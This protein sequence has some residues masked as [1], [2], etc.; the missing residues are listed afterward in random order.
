MSAWHWIYNYID[1]LEGTGIS[2][3]GVKFNI[4]GENNWELPTVIWL[5]LDLVTGT[6]DVPFTEVTES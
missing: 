1:T 4:Q 5:T 3:A 6:A 2:I